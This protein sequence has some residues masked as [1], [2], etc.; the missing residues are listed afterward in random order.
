[1]QSACRIVDSLW[2][3]T[4]AAPPSWIASVDLAERPSHFRCRGVSAISAHVEALAPVD[5][6]W[7]VKSSSGIRLR[8]F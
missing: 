1:M 2:A 8:R 5:R 6:F 3:T 4:T 7:M